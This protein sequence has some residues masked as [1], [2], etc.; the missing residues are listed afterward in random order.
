M[1]LP[2]VGVCLV[3]AVVVRLS[4]LFRTF[5]PS[6]FDCFSWHHYVVVVRPLRPTFEPTNWRR[7]TRNLRPSWQRSPRRGTRCVRR[8]T[9]RQPRRPPPRPPPAHRFEPASTRR[10]LPV[11]SMNLVAIFFC[12][13]ARFLNHVCPGIAFREVQ[14]KVFRRTKGGRRRN[15]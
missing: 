2:G 6:L 10:N 1:I 5:P 12:L 9:V 4:A 8:P 15:G 14:G 11:R 3:A 7:P 13:F